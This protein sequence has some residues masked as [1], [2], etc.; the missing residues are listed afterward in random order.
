MYLCAGACHG[1][2][3][4]VREQFGGVLSFHQMGLR[5]RIKVTSLGGKRLIH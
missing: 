5:E 2:C 4:E 1:M 3:V